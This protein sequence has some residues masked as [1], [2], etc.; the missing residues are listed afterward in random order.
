MIDWMIE[1]T[2]AF[3]CSDQTFF[4]AVGIMDRYFSK[5]TEQAL[6]DPVNSH[7]FT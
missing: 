3:K 2:D 5:L 4:L 6:A 7:K 1:V